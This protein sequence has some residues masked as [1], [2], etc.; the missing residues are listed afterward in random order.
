[1]LFRSKKYAKIAELNEL[2]YSLRPFNPITTGLDGHDE[3]IVWGGRGVSNPNKN[4]DKP[5]D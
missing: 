3:Q 1:V 4:D 5:N 2:N